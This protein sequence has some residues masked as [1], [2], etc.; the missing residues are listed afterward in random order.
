MEFHNVSN[1]F[2]G[3]SFS[4]V[5]IIFTDLSYIFIIKFIGNREII[6]LK[7]DNSEGMI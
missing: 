3:K 7:K 5:K 1:S 2:L 6:P 4:N